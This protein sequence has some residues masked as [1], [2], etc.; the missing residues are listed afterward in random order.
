MTNN[1]QYTKKKIILKNISE[2]TL[3]YQAVAN[4]FASSCSMM[5][6]Q[7]F[8]FAHKSRGCLSSG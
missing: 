3:A 8:C 6:V 5:H 1:L 7:S 4:P 2:E